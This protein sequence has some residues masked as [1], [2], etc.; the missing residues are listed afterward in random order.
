[1]PIKP[2]HFVAIPVENLEVAV[3]AAYGLSRAVGLGILHFKEGPMPPE[4]IEQLLSHPTPFKHV[5]MDYVHGRQVKL[6][7]YCHPEDGTKALIGPRWFDHTDHDLIELLKRC[8][9]TD[10]EEAIV[11]ARVAQE[12]DREDD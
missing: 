9:I 3:Q 5:S 6:T 4:Q 11:A 7:I 10:P 8:G 12:E 2:N 1:M